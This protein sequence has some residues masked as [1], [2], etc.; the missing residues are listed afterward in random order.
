MKHSA[1]EIAN[2]IQ[3]K[4][5]LSSNSVYTIYDG[6]NGLTHTTGSMEYRD[7]NYQHVLN[8]MMMDDVLSG[9]E[10]IDSVKFQLDQ[11]N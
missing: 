7:K 3:E 10:L 4:V 1:K 5:N 8:F 9:D 6:P 2:Y 11:Q